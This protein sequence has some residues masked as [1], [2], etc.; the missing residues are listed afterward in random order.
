MLVA[1][2]GSGFVEAGVAAAGA[3]VALEGFAA[4]SVF[5]VVT[6][7]LCVAARFMFRA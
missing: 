5:F 7:A 3:E 2:T 6:S 1:A 4:A